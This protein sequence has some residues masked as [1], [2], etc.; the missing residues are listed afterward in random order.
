[1]TNSSRPES[2]GHRSSTQK[3]LPQ[4]SKKEL[5]K[6]KAKTYVDANGFNVI[7]YQTQTSHLIL[8]YNDTTMI[9]T[10]NSQVRYSGPIQHDIL[11]KKLKELDIETAK[12]DSAFDNIFDDS[13]FDFDKRLE[14][15]D[16]DFDKWNESLDKLLND[17]P[18]FSS[19]PRLETTNCGNNNQNSSKH[20][21]SQNYY[22]QKNIHRKRSN[23]SNGCLGCFLWTILIFVIVCLI[24]YGM[25]ALG[26]AI[27]DFFANIFNAIFN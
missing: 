19:T 3:S 12:L 9:Y 21:R 7:E 16:R 11:D 8:R 14:L 15:F 10:H 4:V 2:S 24:F 18:T 23:E 1:M 20:T 22:Y 5:S 26:G 25:G 13:S 6:G 27:F 17:F